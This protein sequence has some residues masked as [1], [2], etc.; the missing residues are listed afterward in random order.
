MI[1]VTKE[2]MLA[3]VEQITEYNPRAGLTVCPG[4]RVK[5]AIRNLIRTAPDAADVKRLVEAA[6][7]VSV[8]VSEFMRDWHKG[9]FVLPKLAKLDA[10]AME[11]PLCQLA[12]ALAPLTKGEK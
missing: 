1:D 9:D 2:E 11:N 6:D 4:R 10:A 3:A 12:E 8:V 5:D 7:S